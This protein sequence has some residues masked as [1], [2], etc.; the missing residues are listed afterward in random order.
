MKKNNEKEH[1]Q[2]MDKELGGV[3]D[4]PPDYLSIPVVIKNETRSVKSSQVYLIS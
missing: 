2:I 4:R 1:N 3:A